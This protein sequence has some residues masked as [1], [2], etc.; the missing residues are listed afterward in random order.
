M[1]Q[2]MVVSVLAEILGETARSA[3]GTDV[4]IFPGFVLP[5]GELCPDAR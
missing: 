3:Y 2:T 1:A 5:T 4:L